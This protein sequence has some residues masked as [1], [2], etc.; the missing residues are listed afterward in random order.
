MLLRLIMETEFHSRFHRRPQ[1][2]L[3]RLRSCGVFDFGK[4]ILGNQMV[5]L[6]I[7]GLASRIR[8]RAYLTGGHLFALRMLSAANNGWIL[9][10]DQHCLNSSES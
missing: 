6:A 1:Q 8:R 7:E 2:Q 9:S 10:K 3:A 4:T 5:T